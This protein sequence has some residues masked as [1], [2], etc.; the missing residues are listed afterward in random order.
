MMQP[1]E[2]AQ[3]ER[4]VKHLL[5]TPVRERGEAAYKIALSNLFEVLF[6]HGGFTTLGSLRLLVDIEQV[7]RENDVESD[8]PD[9]LAHLERHQSL[10]A[11]VH[12]KLAAILDRSIGIK[13]ILYVHLDT[14]QQLAEPIGVSFSLEAEQE[15]EEFRLGIDV[16]SDRLRRFVAHYLKLLEESDA[17][18]AARDIRPVILVAVEAYAEEERSAAVHALFADPAAQ[19]GH[20]YGVDIIVQSGTGGGDTVNNTNEEMKQAAKLAEIH[21]FRI[22]NVDRKLWDVH[23]SIDAPKIYEGGS[24]GLAIAIGLLA[25]LLKQP[26][27]CY[28][29][30]SGTV[31]LDSGRVGPVDRIRDK[32]LAAQRIG[33]RR[34][35]LPRENLAEV[36]DLATES[37][38]LIGVDS[39]EEAWS[40]I[41]TFASATSA[42]TSRTA[43]VRQ[44]ALEC[45]RRRLKIASEEARLGFVRLTVTDHQTENMVDVFQGKKGITTSIGGKRDTPLYDAVKSTVAAIFGVASPPPAKP[46]HRSLLVRSAD[47]RV[48]VAEA[49]RSVGSFE[50]KSEANC[51]Y[52]LDFSALRERV[53]VKQFASGTLI[54]HQMAV[55]P[56]G[57]PLFTHLCRQAEIVLG[58]PTQQEGQ[59]GWAG[60]RQSATALDSGSPK[61][62]S[63]TRQQFDTPWIGTD[64]S[65]KGDYFGPL[66]SAAVYVDEIAHEHLAALGVRDSKLLSDGRIRNL[67]PR[68]RAICKHHK[69]VPIL[70]KRYNTLYDEFR[71]EGKT[72]TTLLAWGHARALEDLLKV[73]DCDNVIADQFADEHYIQSRLLEK[74]RSRNLNLV[75]MHRAEANIAVAAAS[76]LARDKFL[77][78][79][80]SASRK[81]GRPLP[82]GASEQVIETARDIVG[83]FG[84]DELR[85]V[86][87]LHFK[88][89]ERVLAGR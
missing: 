64:E 33:F 88:T 70:P 55:G 58:I 39:V 49:L 75:Q 8:D 57:D 87:K 23:W 18:N 44:F 61:Q 71:R 4:L 82:K 62:V 7:L 86:A 41:T 74:G 19:K 76:I 54:F 53:M 67:A 66:V 68:I 52:R 56:E 45:M 72:L 11:H 80:E 43:I 63:E 6:E 25:R 85:E 69:E 30:F 38:F 50:E 77:A 16:P 14:W 21:A 28:T 37:F 83:R 22:A 29:A 15:L 12:A 10:M 27:D 60:V 47:D 46:M 2:T 78:W 34:I 51:E 13:D 3:A 5:G 48:K 32:A 84:Q 40:D 26:V 59:I 81:Y 31:S 17:T 73:V 35:Y 20:C 36:K 65:G 24:I 89:T 9:S 42:A 1:S 79:L